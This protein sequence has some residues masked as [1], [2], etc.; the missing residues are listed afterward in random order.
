MRFTTLPNDCQVAYLNEGE[1]HFLYDEI[2]VKKRYL[3]DG[4]SLGPGD[5]VFDVGANIGLAT[6]FFFRVCPRIRV[7]AF[8]PLPAAFHALEAN[9]HRHDLDATLFRCALGASEGQRVLTYYPRNAVC[10]T[11]YPDLAGESEITRRY[12][13]ARG[14]ER[15][16]ADEVVEYLFAEAE[17][18]SCR[19]ESLSTILRALSIER[20][21]LLKIDVEKSELDVL[22]GID[23][24][25]WPKIEQVVAEI[26]GDEQRLAS[27]E[28]MLLARGF[29]VRSAREHLLED[30]DLALISARR[31]T[32]VHG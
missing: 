27:V 11:L 24:R 10:S 32:P 7:F 30:T 2:F 19:V 26:H 4:V 16:Y 21:A 20:I 9:V 29:D 6:L 3:P 18:T 12:L 17:E 13:A 23:D 14:F 28:E 5:C 22:A 1:T 25:D 8:E 31:A 15:E